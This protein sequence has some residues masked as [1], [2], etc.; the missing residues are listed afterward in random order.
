[1]DRHREAKDSSDVGRAVHNSLNSSNSSRTED[2]VSREVEEAEL[3][4]EVH[5]VTDVEHGAIHR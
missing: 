1:M 3:E 2:K 5:N 4:E